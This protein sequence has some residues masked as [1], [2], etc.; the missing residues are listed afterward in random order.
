MIH[1]Y[2][3]FA[4][5]KIVTTV[6]GSVMDKSIHMSPIEQVEI[7]DI[8]FEGVRLRRLPK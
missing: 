3:E 4:D 7:D 5:G 6:D 2:Y 8:L 1:N